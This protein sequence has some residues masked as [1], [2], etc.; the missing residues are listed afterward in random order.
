MD[1]E[2]QISDALMG[3]AMEL[4]FHVIDEVRKIRPSVVV[5]QLRAGAGHHRSFS[6]VPGGKKTVT[7]HTPYTRKRTYEFFV[8]SVMDLFEALDDQEKVRAA[9]GLGGI[10][11]S[12]RHDERQER[13]TGDTD[14]DPFRGKFSLGALYEVA[15]A[16]R[17]GG[18]IPEEVSMEFEA[19][20]DQARLKTIIIHLEYPEKVE[21]KQ[22]PEI[23]GRPLEKLSSREATEIANACVEKV[24][25]QAESRY[26]IAPNTLEAYVSLDETGTSVF[27]VGLRRYLD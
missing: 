5:P 11:P 7:V 13:F 23:F 27:G 2:P 8:I 15:T 3:L 17:R 14:A 10:A 22:G 6:I 9:R 24:R 25:A 21:K 19:H 12:Q 4:R 26:H 1:L 18:D 20:W 16:I